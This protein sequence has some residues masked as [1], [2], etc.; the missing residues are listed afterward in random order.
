[1]LEVFFSGFKRFAMALVGARRREEA[2][3]SISVVPF[4]GLREAL[5]TLE[6]LEMFSVD[7][8]RLI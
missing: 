8:V 5:E 2:E 4:C 3:I 1:M 6:E 7:F